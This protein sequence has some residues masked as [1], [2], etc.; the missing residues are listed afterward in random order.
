MATQ[1]TLG[2]KQPETRGHTANNRDIGVRGNKAEARVA[3]RKRRKLNHNA[4]RVQAEWA[5]SKVQ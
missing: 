1:G 2:L 4:T 5:V 3:N